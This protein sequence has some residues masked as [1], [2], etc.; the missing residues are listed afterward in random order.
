[1]KIIAYNAASFPTI[2]DKNGLVIQKIADGFEKSSGFEFVNKKDILVTQQEDGKVKMIRNFDL[3]KY[4]IIDLDVFTLTNDSGISGITSTVFGNVTNVFLSYTERTENDRGEISPFGNSYR[5]YRYE[6]DPN[7]LALFNS[8]LVLDLPSASSIES[9]RGKIVIGPDDMLYTV[10]SEMNLEERRQN[11]SQEDPSNYSVYKY[12]PESAAV[13]KTTRDGLPLTEKGFERSYGFGIQNSAGL[14]FDPLTG[15]LWY[16]KEGSG[17]WDRIKVVNPH[18]NNGECCTE[19]NFKLPANTSI[20]YGKDG[21]RND[22]SE[23]LGSN[24]SSVSTFL[25][26]NSSALGKEY[27]ND[28]FVGDKRGYI[29]HFDLDRNRENVISEGNISSH[30]FAAD[31]GPIS[32]MK[33]GPDKALYVLTFANNTGSILEKGTGSL[34][35]I[36]KDKIDLPLIRS[37]AIN[38][39]YLWL[40]STFIIIITV[41]VTLKYFTHITKRVHSLSKK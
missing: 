17:I 39:D 13:L 31:L 18:F 21:F 15:Y 8:T 14:T 33:I 23:I 24:S 37:E 32:D 30:V 7:F 28:L 12:K 41:L 9:H 29:Y 34:Y 36:A 22:E 3:K 4:P 40:I 10:I 5:I 2:L 26:M 38:A 25:F 19:N 11:M 16:T 6:W 20:L 35:R 27:T 1:M